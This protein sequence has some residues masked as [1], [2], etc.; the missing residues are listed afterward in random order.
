MGTREQESLASAF[1]PEDAMRSISFFLYVLTLTVT[2]AAQDDATLHGKWRGTGE[3]LEGIELIFEKGLVLSSGEPIPYSIPRP[4]WLTLGDPPE[5]EFGYEVRRD[6]LTLRVPWG[7]ASFRRV[8]PVA[9]EQPRG[10][11]SEGD[12]FA[13]TFAAE[14]VVLVLRGSAEQGYSGQ[15]ALEEQL[16]PVEA[17][18]DGE[19][20]RGAV[21]GAEPSLPFTATLEGDELTLLLGEK[22]YTLRGA[23][24][25]PP[26]LEG[27]YDGETRRYEHPRGY[28]GLDLP[29]GWKVGAL[30]D[31]GLTFDLG[32]PRNVLPEAIAGL[33]WGRVPEE[34]QNRPVAEL[35]EE[36]VPTL[37]TTLREQGLIIR[38]PDGPIRT[39]RSQEVP[40]AVASFKGRT[41]TG[42]ACRV[43]CGTVIKRDAWVT[44]SGVF[45]AEKEETYLPRLKRVF[46][47]LEPRP[48]ERNPELEARL[49]GLT[50]SSSQYGRITKSAHH[51]S[52]TFAPGNVVHRRLMS[53]IISQPG[54]PGSTTDSER[55]GRYEVCGDILFLFFETG[56]QAGQVLLEGNQVVGFRIGSAQYR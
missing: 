1:Q 12:P 41:T 33:L 24:L 26:E 25:L 3:G 18:L 30:G 32:L 46:V 51:A 15:L 16:H 38:N 40:G 27:V 54:L 44:V 6:E 34:D 55:S 47:S 10:T 23:P 42:V 2:A 29:K 22:R 53:N 49:V 20:L 8:P 4:G 31:E 39:Y 11:E 14:G 45:A 52:Y 17:K 56:Q 37:R 13:R 5:A 50:F 43:W 35:L 36:H 19:R 21:G 7:E 48:P 28:L 9:T